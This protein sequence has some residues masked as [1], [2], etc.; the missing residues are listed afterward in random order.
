MRR[1]PLLI[2]LLLSLSGT[3]AYGQSPQASAESH[4]NLGLARYEKG[5]LAEAI[6]EYNAAIEINPRFTKA[7]NAR[8]LA[9][10]RIGDQDRAIED[11][12]QAIKI[13]P[14]YAV[15]YSNR[16]L[17]RAGKGDH[18]GA[19]ADFNKAIEVNPRSAYA[20]YVRGHARKVYYDHLDEAI[21]DFSKA[22]EISPSYALAYYHRGL[23]RYTKGDYDGAVADGTKVIEFDQPP[24]WLSIAADAYALRGSAKLQQGKDTEAQHDFDSAIKLD[25]R[26]KS[27]LEAESA[28]IKQSRK[29]QE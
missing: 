2:L 16:G 9:R 17:A 26:W 23:A 18:D 7:Y 29:P 5:E 4:L 14:N 21:T 8:G 11:Y 3:V 20:Y 1:F 13:D 10:E 25:S 27:R 15:A 19:V 24:G 22:I 6:V 28:K 12:T